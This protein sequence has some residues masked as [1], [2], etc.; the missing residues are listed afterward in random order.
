MSINPRD[1]KAKHVREQRDAQRLRLPLGEARKEHVAY[2]VTQSA[3]TMTRCNSAASR[4]AGGSTGSN[5]RSAWPKINAMLGYNAPL[6]AARSAPA[7]RH[8]QSTGVA[9]R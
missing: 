9:K 1:V 3:T 8:S 4:T 5:A 7:G 6:I 2:S